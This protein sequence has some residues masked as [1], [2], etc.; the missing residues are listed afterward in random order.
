MIAHPEITILTSDVH[1]TVKNSPEMVNSVV[2]AAKRAGVPYRVQP[3]FLG[4]A[5]DAGPFSR[6][7]LKATTL[8]PF[9]VSTT[10]G[11]LLSPEMGHARSIDDRTAT[12][13]VEA[14]FRVGM[15]QRGG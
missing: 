7:G 4:T 10:D 5:G 8:N 1:G 3:A 9:K 12:E 15:S 2:A 6:A 13:R 14:H 11:G